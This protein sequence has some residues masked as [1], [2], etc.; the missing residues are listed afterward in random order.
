MAFKGQDNLIIGGFPKDGT[1]KF[2]EEGAK[3][4]VDRLS[5]T[6]WAFQDPLAL[7]ATGRVCVMKK[8]EDA[9]WA[10]MHAAVQ[11]YKKGRRSKNYRG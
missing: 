3:L 1:A 7:Y 4:V 9:S 5:T 10:M 6:K 8:R 11:E 2:R